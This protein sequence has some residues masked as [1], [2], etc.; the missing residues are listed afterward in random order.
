MGYAKALGKPVVM[1]TEN[2]S[3][4]DKKMMEG[5]HCILCD[6]FVT[7]IYRMVWEAVAL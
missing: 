1:Y 7:A 6:D 3:E 5:S 4:E 2:E